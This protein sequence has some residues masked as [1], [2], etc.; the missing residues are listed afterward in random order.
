MTWPLPCLCMLCKKKQK[1]TTQK[2]SRTRTC[3]N[4]TWYAV[5]TKSKL[6]INTPAP[7]PRFPHPVL[8]DQ[9]MPKVL[10]SRAFGKFSQPSL[11]SLSMTR[12]VVQAPGEA[13]LV[14]SAPQVQGNSYNLIRSSRPIGWTQ[15]PG[16]LGVN[17]SDKLIGSFPNL[18]PVL[19]SISAEPAK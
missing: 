3:R 1:T 17:L 14:P 6:Y 13:L 15:R 2:Q 19:S 16:V 4:K 9:A 8:P 7:A 11:A 10:L 5:Q 12:V 18:D